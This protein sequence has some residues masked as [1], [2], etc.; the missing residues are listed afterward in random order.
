M[1][2]IETI[3]LYR[4]GSMIRHRLNRR[5][6]IVARLDLRRIGVVR[7]LP[8]DAYRELLGSV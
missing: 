1:S 7:V 3:K 6:Q 8:R 2:E 5:P 4:V